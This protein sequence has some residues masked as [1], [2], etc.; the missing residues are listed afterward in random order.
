MLLLV[1]IRVI[2]LVKCFIVF[3]NIPVILLLGELKTDNFLEAHCGNLS[4]NSVMFPDDRLLS[5]YRVSSSQRLFKSTVNVAAFPLFEKSKCWRDT[6]P[7]SASGKG[8]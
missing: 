4:T 6:I 7:P 2:K 8:P 3:G 1:R 5:R